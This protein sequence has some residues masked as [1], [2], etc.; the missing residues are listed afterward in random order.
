M[1]AL[2]KRNL[3]GTTTSTTGSPAAVNSAGYS[4]QTNALTLGPTQTGGLLLGA[5]E[6]L[7]SFG[8]APVAGQ[9]D[10]YAMDWSL[11]GNTQPPA[12]SATLQGRYVGTF[13]PRPLTGNTATAF[14][15]ELDGVLLSNKADYYISNNGTSQQISAGWT[16][17]CAPWAP[18]S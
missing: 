18:G 15:L 12:P 10:L 6:L 5:F 13:S 1:S 4:V 3:L 14:K 2:G 16:L 8:A 11:D 17:S 9:V 7:C